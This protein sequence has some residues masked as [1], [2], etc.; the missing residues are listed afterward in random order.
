MACLAKDGAGRPASA[1]TSG[2]AL[3]ALPDGDEWSE[4]DAQAWW[5]RFDS[6]RDTMLAGAAACAPTT[7]TVDLSHHDDVLPAV[8]A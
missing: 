7:L 6:L 5:R 2:A 8:A 3:R 1:R 4:A